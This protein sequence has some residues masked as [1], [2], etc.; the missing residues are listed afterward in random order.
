MWG[1]VNAAIDVTQGQPEALQF[2]PEE[3]SSP[4]D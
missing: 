4:V 1:Q 3:L 2:L